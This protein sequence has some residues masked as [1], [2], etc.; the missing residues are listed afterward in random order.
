[1]NREFSVVKTSENCMC[2]GPSHEESTRILGLKK[3]GTFQ[4]FQHGHSD[5]ATPNSKSVVDSMQNA[6]YC[7]WMMMIYYKK[8]VKKTYKT[9]KTKHWNTRNEIAKDINFDC[10]KVHENYKKTHKRLLAGGGG[11]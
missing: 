9:K 6:F 10:E 7:Y 8:A 2:F 5:S 1:V 3:K 11:I 4:G